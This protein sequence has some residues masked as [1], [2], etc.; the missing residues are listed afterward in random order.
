M[1]IKFKITALFT[2]LVTAILLLLSFSIYYF[3]SLERLEAFK[4]RL[5]GRANNNAQLYT[6]FGDSSTTMLKRFDSGS[7]NT[8]QDKSV[9]IYNYLNQPVY[10]FNAHGVE[11]PTTN[12]SMLERARLDG[13]TYYK[14]LTRDVIAFHHIDSVNRIVVVVAAYDL[15]GWNRLS[16]LQKLLMTSLLIGI[17]AAAIVGFLFSRQ[18][19]M[20]ITQIIREVK[21]ISSQSLSHR[22]EAG[23]GH[24]ELHQLANTFNELLNRLQDSFTT[25]RRFI[26]NASHE[27]STPLTSISSQ[28]EVTLQKDRNT[29]EYR[30]VLQS[31]YEDVQQMRQL[32]KSLLEIAKTGSQGTIELHEVRIDEVLFKVMSDVQK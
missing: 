25:Q 31:I 19:L 28:L 16:Q 17:A 1:K 18:L 5:K 26:S 9:V 11:T 22:I 12:I 15:D 29:E 8:L 23:S 4:K 10:E 30:Q 13:E 7:T 2:L 21:D 32:T 14:I 24:D 27:L 3:T 6:Y 20:P